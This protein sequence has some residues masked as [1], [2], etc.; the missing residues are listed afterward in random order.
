MGIRISI[1]GIRENDYWQERR[2]FSHSSKKL[3]ENSLKSDAHLLRRKRISEDYP[4]HLKQYSVNQI[5]I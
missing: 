1:I 5:K 3:S 4:L 2:I